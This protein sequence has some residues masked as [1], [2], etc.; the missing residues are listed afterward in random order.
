MSTYEPIQHQ[1]YY[2]IYNCGING[3]NL[4]IGPKD[5][6]YFLH[7]YKR[8]I[9]TI[10]ETF[11]WCLMKNHFHL[12]IQV[13][14]KLEIG[15]YKYTK[16]SY[17]KAI[18]DGDLSK[19][20]TFDEVK[21]LSSTDEETNTNKKPN[22]TNH[23]A[24]LFI[25]YAKYFNKKYN[26]HGSLFE[27]P[28]HRK[29][30]IHERYFKNLVVYIHNNPIKHGFVKHPLEWGWSSYLSCISSNENIVSKNKTI[31]WFQNSE[32]FKHVHEKEL[33]VLEIEK[34]LGVI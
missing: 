16:A 5:Y 23:F 29:P 4:F 12:L 15:N 22:P 31:S 2:H 27:K 14:S 3:C 18:D 1:K 33:D 8:Y 7:L 24:H 25:S 19:L 26:R 30:I 32:N 13:K 17:Q 21:W 6:D 10:A 11:A 28:F 20:L 34:M 9:S